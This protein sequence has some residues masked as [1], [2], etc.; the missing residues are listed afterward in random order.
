MDSGD[1]C[2]TIWMWLIPQN[3]IFLNGV[4]GLLK[5]CFWRHC[6][7]KQGVFVSWGAAESLL[8]IPNTSDYSADKR[9]ISD[10][11]MLI[12][13]IL[14]HHTRTLLCDTSSSSGD[15][16]DIIYTKTVT[17]FEILEYLKHL[18]TISHA[19]SR[20]VLWLFPLKFW[21]ILELKGLC[22]IGFH[23]NIKGRVKSL[24]QILVMGE[25]CHY[26]QYAFAGCLL[27]VTVLKYLF[28]RYLLVANYMPMKRSEQ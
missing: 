16:W 25:G 10:N 9:E 26:T 28:S 18:E 17:H 7:F 5:A 3:C 4:S 1:G 21:Q 15:S 20:Q 14:N 11:H 6:I 19:T 24:L 13:I 8:W 2:T 23:L 12:D 22:G 27:C